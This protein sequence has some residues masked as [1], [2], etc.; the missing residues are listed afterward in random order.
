[1]NRWLLLLC[2]LG[3]ACGGDD[4]DGGDLPGGADAGPDGEGDGGPD[5]PVGCGNGEIDGDEACDD[6]DTE[7]SGGCSADCSAASCLVPLT[8][9]T[10]QAGIDDGACVTV[11]VMPGTYQENLVIA[12][13]MVIEKT[14]VGEVIVDGGGTG[15][16]ITQNGLLVRLTGFTVQNGY[17]EI[18]AGINNSL[19][20]LI[21]DE[22]RVID[23][24]AEGDA[25]RGGGVYSGGQLYLD[26]TE[27]SGNTVQNGDVA[28]IAPLRGG[29]IASVSLLIINNQSD[30]HDNQ[31]IASGGAAIG[32]G[33]ATLGGSTT[34]IS[35]QSQVR[36]NRAE[37]TAAAGDARATGGGV[38]V[39]DLGSSLE[40]RSGASVTGNQVISTADGGTGTAIGGGVGCGEDSDVTMTNAVVTGNSATGEG[41]SGAAWGGGLSAIA[42]EIQIATSDL[43]SNSVNS[44]GEGGGGGLSVTGRAIAGIADSRIA[45]NQVSAAGSASGGGILFAAPGAVTATVAGSTISGNSVSAGSASGGGLAMSSGDNSTLAMVNSTVSGNTSDD[46][47]GGVHLLQTGAR[48]TRTELRNATITGNQAAAGGGLQVV[49]AGGASFVATTLSATIV[50]GNTATTGPETRCSGTV[51]PVLSSEGYNLWGDTTGCT[52][53]GAGEDDVTGADPL[54]QPLGDNGGPTATHAPGAGSP[55]IDGGDPA[56]CPDAAGGTLVVDQRGMARPS[57]AT[58]DIGSVEVE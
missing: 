27:V 2:L 20:F 23:S 40:L 54:L 21:L 49:Q 50:Y 11:W 22:M 34:R 39:N 6:G 9:E 48:T 56:G 8:H 4:D 3:F 51:A 35:G 15:R 17:A 53:I 41:A 30:I 43:S 44:A 58:C 52:I 10:I 31:V 14:G 45:D 12:R 29:G 18:G 36:D 13:D 26:R 19:G 7:D 28:A 25:P 32:G 47:G 37:S 33:I 57:G 55:A 5:I 24:T 46:D 16:V 1:M 42:C 38:G